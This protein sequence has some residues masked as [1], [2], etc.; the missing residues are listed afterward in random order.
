MRKV[1]VVYSR[2]Y[3]TAY[4]LT[5]GVPHILRVFTRQYMADAY[6]INLVNNNSANNIDFY[7][8]KTELDEEDDRDE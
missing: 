4:G 3:K 6:L 5:D 2:V 1:W 7:L 8:E